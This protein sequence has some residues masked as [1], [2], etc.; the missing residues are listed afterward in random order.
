MA[1]PQR[2]RTEG[3]RTALLGGRSL[4]RENSGKK[5]ILK[6][7][8]RSHSRQARHR[9]E[10]ARGKKERKR[11]ANKNSLRSGN[12]NCWGPSGFLWVAGNSDK[13]QTTSRSQSRTVAERGVEGVENVIRLASR[14]GAA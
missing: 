13:G 9:C 10:L 7:T 6:E 8:T 11:T 1:G 3:M 2:T 14:A 5:E 4:S 12:S